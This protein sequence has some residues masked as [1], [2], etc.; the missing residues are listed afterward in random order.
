MRDSRIDSEFR[1]KLIKSWIIKE[2]NS[3]GWSYIISSALPELINYNSTF[4]CFDIGEKTSWDK[5]EVRI[6]AKYLLSLYQKKK[7]VLKTSH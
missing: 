1:A 7:E 5:E 3:V 2:F 4:N 6:I